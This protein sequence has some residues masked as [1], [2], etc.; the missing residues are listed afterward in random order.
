MLTT[1]LTCALGA[2]GLV[3]KPFN[4]AHAYAKEAMT[5]YHVGV[6]G[7]IEGAGPLSVVLEFKSTVKEIIEEGANLSINVTKLDANIDGNPLPTDGETTFDLKVSK[8]GV[9]QEFEMQGFSS[10]IYLALLTQYL[11]GKE[12]N[13]GD[14]FDISKKSDAFSY[15]GKGT[16]TEDKVIED[17]TYAVLTTECEFTPG[18]QEPGAI[19][20]TVLLDKATGKISSCEAMLETP[21][22][23]FKM[24]VKLKH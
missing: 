3:A 8:S 4:F 17:R 22:G 6:T 2:S 11:P 12:L 10:V 18:D 19:K 7:E 14:T 23:E 9:P 20:A 15:S 13:V 16:Y 21:D 1:I 24:I 5:E